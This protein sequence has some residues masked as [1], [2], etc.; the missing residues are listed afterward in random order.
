MI[1]ENWRG[2][3]KRFMGKVLSAERKGVRVLK[4]V[5]DVRLSL[6][7]TLTSYLGKLKGC[8]DF[9]GMVIDLS[10]ADTIDSTALGLIVKIAIC[11]REKF[12]CVTSIISPREDVT[13]LLESMAIEQVCTILAKPVR[14]QADLHE[15]PQEI[16][17]EET[18][19]GQIL[20]AHKTLMELDEE[21]FD[22]FH[23]LV[24]ALE[25]EGQGQQ[26]SLQRMG[27]F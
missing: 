13:R 16:C 17:N 4:F 5:G 14:Q 19:R 21:N 1:R 11:T 9:R 15:L 10:E 27:K 24:D 7:P 23:D 20:D 18:L 3:R 8:Q 6:S 26:D 22:K 12:G 2:N 25:N